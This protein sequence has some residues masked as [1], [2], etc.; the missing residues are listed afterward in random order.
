MPPHEYFL[1]DKPWHVTGS[2]HD[3]ADTVT[4]IGG[5]LAGAALAYFLSQ[6]KKR[7]ITLIERHATLASQ[8]SEPPGV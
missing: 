3:A 5:G 4:I 1:N 2:N 7:E 8:A 6:N